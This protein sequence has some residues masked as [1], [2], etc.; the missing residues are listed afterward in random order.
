M[1]QRRQRATAQRGLTLVEVLL[2]TALLVGGGGAILMGMRYSTIH[3]EYLSQHQVAMNAAQGLLERLS[4]TGFATLLGPQYA[5]ARTPNPGTV[6]RCFLWDLNCNGVLE[7]GEVTA[8]PLNGGALDL[9]I[10][11]PPE[12]VAINGANPGLLDI[13]VAACWQSRG[14]AIGEDRNCNGILDL[15]EDGSTTINPAPN[16]WVD[17]PVMVSTRVGRQ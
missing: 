14:H 1:T 13:H 5:A 4:A 16:G 2:G 15:G 11:Q 6:Q 17:S 9:Q 8:D 3:A 7:A 12:D 10:R